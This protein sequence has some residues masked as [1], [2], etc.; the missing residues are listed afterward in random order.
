[1]TPHY[2]SQATFFGKAVGNINDMQ[3]HLG[4]W[5]DENTPPDAVFAT[6]DAGALRFFSGRTMIDLVGLVSPD[7]IHRNMTYEEKVQYL[8][9]NDCT[10][11][12]YFDAI[13][14]W[15]AQFFPSSAYSTIYTVTLPENV[16]CGSDTMS[17][18]EINWELTDY[19]VNS[20]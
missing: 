7:I 15:W 13:F 16:I 10:H 3:V 6:H 14:F 17:V 9:D 5:L 20:V 18:I 1:M 12:V 8:Y 2:V 11:F 19:P 4:Q